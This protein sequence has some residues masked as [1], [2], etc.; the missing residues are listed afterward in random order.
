M[1]M[2]TDRLFLRP[3]FPEDW[4]AVFAGIANEGTVRMLASAPWPYT[5]QDARDHCSRA[6]RPGELR[7]AITVPGLPGAPLVGQVGI[8]PREGA[9]DAEL[10]YWIA[11]AHRGRGYA[12]EAVA[13]VL[14]IARAIGMKRIVA[15][16]FLDNPASGA[17]LRKCGF[18]Q[19]GEVRPETSAGRGGELALVRRYAL[20]L[21]GV[22]FVAAAGAE[23]AA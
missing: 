9:L 8:G 18:S 19:T 2:R 12:S 5:Q 14:E 7:F 15:G 16:H 4:R 17:V 20:D 21:G 23:Q 22:A 11:R 13:G 10:G 1:F 6:P 3:P